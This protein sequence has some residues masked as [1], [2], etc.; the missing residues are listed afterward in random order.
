MTEGTT[1]FIGGLSDRARDKDIEDFFDKYG[2]VTQ[3][4]LRDRYGFVDFDDRRDAEEWFIIITLLVK[5]L[6]LATCHKKQA[7]G[8]SFLIP[9]SGILRLRT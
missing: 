5:N 3:I 7:C 8:Q 9:D 1:V 4:R 6:A 2:K